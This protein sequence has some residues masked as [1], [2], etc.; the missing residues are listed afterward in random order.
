MKKYFIGIDFSKEKFDASIVMNGNLTDYSHRK[1]ENTL[2]GCKALVMWIAAETGSQREEWL[3][4]GEHT[5]LYSL[6][7][8]EYLVS[9][10]VFMWLEDPSQIHHCQGIRREKTD[11]SDSYEIAKYAFRYQDKARMY[12]PLSV[13]Q[14]RLKILFTYRSSLV[15]QR[16]ALAQSTSEL[17][18]VIARDTATRIIS[19]FTKS[20]VARINVIIKKVEKMM[21]DIINGEEDMCRNFQLICSVKGIGLVNAVSF[22]ILTDNFTR[23]TDPRKFATYAGMAPFER[24]SGTS[25]YKGIHTSHRAHAGM[26]ALLT[27]AARSAINFNPEIKAYYQRKIAEGKPPRVVVNNVRNKLIQRVFAV[28]RE[29]VPYSINYCW[30]S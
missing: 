13:R 18:K 25:V 15:A 14:R 3:V 5:G 11:E 9:Q 27:E 4:C 16:T 19:D 23:I 8:S 22:L 20:L 6:E 30:A 1:F 24:S 2:S 7:L 26:K 17:R 28:V 10:S 21:I 12:K 29:G